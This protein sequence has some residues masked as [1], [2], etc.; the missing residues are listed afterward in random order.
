MR[1]RAGLTADDLSRLRAD[2]Q[3][4]VALRFMASGRN[5]EALDAFDRALEEDPDNVR[6]LMGRAVV[7]GRL[8]RYDAALN[9]A[10][11]VVALAPDGG[12]AYNM[13]G[14]IFK[15]TGKWDEAQQ[16]FS[17]AIAVEPA[18]HSHY[19][20]FACFWAARGEAELCRHF[21]TQALRL[22]PEGN[23]YAATDV[24]L[25]RYRE[26]DWFQELIA[27]KPATMK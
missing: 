26:E 19:Y 27:F 10:A 18:E 13:R 11:E 6:A 16:S 7:L 2:T 20:N 5:E 21:L 9:A 14:I 15:L 1:P 4:T 22:Y 3:V 25:A 12:R 24:D 23:T 8:A 17:Q